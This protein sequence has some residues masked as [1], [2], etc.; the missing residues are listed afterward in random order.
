MASQ[1]VVISISGRTSLFECSRVPFNGRVL[2]ERSWED[3]TQIHWIDTHSSR[4][5]ISGVLAFRRYRESTLH[6]YGSLQKYCV[7]FSDYVMQQSIY[8]NIYRVI[9]S[10]ELEDSDQNDFLLI[11]RLGCFLLGGNGR[12]RSMEWGEQRPAVNALKAPDLMSRLI[13]ELFLRDLICK[14]LWIDL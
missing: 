12:L 4:G 1:R 6:W 7:P 2:R 10:F 5:K 14:K 3:Q 8:I 11:A 9:L 13:I